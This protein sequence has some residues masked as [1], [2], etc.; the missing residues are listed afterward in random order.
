MAVRGCRIS[1]DDPKSKRIRWICE[2]YKRQG[3]SVCRGVRIPD[4]EVQK[5][6]PIEQD[7]FI[8]EVIDNGGEK[9]YTYSSEA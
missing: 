2:R 4:I 5:W 6:L 3:K 7:I 1:R 8:E 9:R